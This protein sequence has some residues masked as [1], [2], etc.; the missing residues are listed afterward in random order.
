M[1][2]TEPAVKFTFLFANAGDNSHLRRK[3]LVRVRKSSVD[4]I[5]GSV[6]NRLWCRIL[7]GCQRD[8]DVL[9]EYVL[10]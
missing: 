1:D 9:K 3:F 7:G 5:V 8:M 2:Y 10:M 4:G 6:R